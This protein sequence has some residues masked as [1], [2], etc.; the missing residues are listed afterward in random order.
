VEPAL[1]VVQ[2][3]APDT[4]TKRDGQPVTTDYSTRRGIRWRRDRRIKVIT[5][6]R[7]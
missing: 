2:H 6:P 1:P 3:G 4:A 7:P 5:L